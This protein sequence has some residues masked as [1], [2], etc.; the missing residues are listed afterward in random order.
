M[1]LTSMHSRMKTSQVPIIAVHLW[2]VVSIQCRG[3]ILIVSSQC[4]TM[5]DH[6]LRTRKRYANTYEPV[7]LALLEDAQDPR[8]PQALKEFSYWHSTELYALPF[9][10]C[11][12]YAYRA[13]FVGFFA[14]RN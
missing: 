12:R 9:Q 5:D 6:A 14:R 10:V 7:F 4:Y 13:E 2:A 8:E 11:H 3:N 1:Y